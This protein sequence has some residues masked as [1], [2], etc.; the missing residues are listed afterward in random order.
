MRPVFGTTKRSACSCGH[1]LPAG[2]QVPARLAAVYIDDDVKIFEYTKIVGPTYIGKG[3]VIGNNNI[4][5]NSYIGMGCVTG[6]STDITRSYIGDNCWFHTNYIGDSVLVGNVSMGSGAKLANLRLDDG[7]IYSTVAGEKI[8]TGRK[9]LGALIGS[10]VRIGVNTSIMPGVKIGKGSFIGSQVM[11][12]KDLPDNSY[13]I[14]KHEYTI[15]RNNSSA[16]EK[17]DEFKKNL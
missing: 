17:R 15:A 1:G 6:F 2:R 5:R 8:A 12:D 9:K 11:L 16:S 7:E 10:G 4:I 14:V 3:S 13:C